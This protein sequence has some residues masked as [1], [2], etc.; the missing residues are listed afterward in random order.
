MFK[1]MYACAMLANRIEIGKQKKAI[2]VLRTSDEYM[3]Q[4][5]AR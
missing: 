1:F 2:L 5:P 3:Q 4:V